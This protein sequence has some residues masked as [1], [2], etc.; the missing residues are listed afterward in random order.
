MAAKQDRGVIVQLLDESLVGLPNSS[1]QGCRMHRHSSTCKQKIQVAGRDPR[2]VKS[3]GKTSFIKNH[4]ARDDDA[5]SGH[6]EAAVPLVGRGIT[7][8]DASC[9]AR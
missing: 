3:E 7:E 5:P 6:V 9:G 2:G 1:G 4:M 8:K